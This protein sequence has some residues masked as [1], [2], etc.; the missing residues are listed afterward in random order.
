MINVTECAAT[1]PVA[2]LYGL[3]VDTGNGAHA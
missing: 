2:V 1:T 3:L